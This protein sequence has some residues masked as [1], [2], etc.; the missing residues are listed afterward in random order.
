M[1]TLSISIIPEKTLYHELQIEIPNSEDGSQKVI[2]GDIDSSELNHSIQ[3]QR[4]LWE[5]NVKNFP[6]RKYI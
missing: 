6:E 2:V 3:L 4:Y 1:R 5:N